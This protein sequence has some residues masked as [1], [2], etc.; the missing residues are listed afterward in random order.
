MIYMFLSNNPSSGDINP[1][2]LS[3]FD[4]VLCVLRFKANTSGVRIIS[5]HSSLFSGPFTVFGPTD[6][7]FKALPEKFVDFLLKNKTLLAD[8]L[9]YHV[10]K[11]KVLSTDL[12]NEQLVPSLQGKNIRINIYKEGKV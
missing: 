10:A 4:Q 8:I 7:A 2:N 11:G 3:C 6:A 9:E 1:S 5:Y 12:K